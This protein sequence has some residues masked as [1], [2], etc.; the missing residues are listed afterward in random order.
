MRQWMP[1][2]QTTVRLKYKPLK[3]KWRCTGLVSLRIRFD[4]GGGL[5]MTDEQVDKIARAIE[6]G[7]AILAMAIMSGC[8]M[9]TCGI[10][11]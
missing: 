2:V 5:H 1:N 7:F 6:N 4:S 11:G 9:M 10:A 8:F 3:H